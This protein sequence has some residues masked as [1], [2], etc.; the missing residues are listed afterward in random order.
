[1][2]VFDDRVFSVMRTHRESGD[3][4][5]ALI[6]VSSEEVTVK[7]G[8]GGRELIGGG[9]VVDEVTMKPYEAMWMEIDGE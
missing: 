3:R 7:T 9:I 2:K 6:N 5:L 1:M 8:Y 4:I